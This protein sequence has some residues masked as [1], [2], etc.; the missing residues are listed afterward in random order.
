MTAATGGSLAELL[1]DKHMDNWLQLASVALKRTPRTPLSFFS[2]F[3][4]VV[5][6]IVFGALYS[7]IT[8]ERKEFFVEFALAFLVVE[9][10]LIL[11]FVWLRPEHL[12]YGADAH[13]EKWKLAFGT[14]K[15][16]ETTKLP[17]CGSPGP[18]CVS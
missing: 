5:G 2:R 1:G 4:W 14:D 9:F 12:L 13:F 7:N 17:T 3:V 6:G 10:L 18:R 8:T 15:S 16:V 11:A